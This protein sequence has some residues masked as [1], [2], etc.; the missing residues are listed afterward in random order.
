MAESDT[1]DSYL[2]LSYSQLGER[3]G[4]SAEAARVRAK[5]RGWKLERSNDGRRIVLVPLS[6]LSDL[7]DRE[8]STTVHGPNRTVHGS[9]MNEP[10]PQLEQRAA[11]AEALAAELP[12]LREQLRSMQEQAAQ[13]EARAAAA[14]ARAEGL[15]AIQEELRGTIAHERQVAA[16]LRQI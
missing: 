16:E 1:S 3:W 13:A 4:L 7:T 11:T 10:G 2:R 15:V 5:R 9:D 6:G 12:Q 8:R 14:E